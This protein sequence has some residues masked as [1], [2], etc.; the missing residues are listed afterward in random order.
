V[1][2]TKEEKAKRERYSAI[3]QA[4]KEKKERYIGHWDPIYKDC[5]ARKEFALLG[6]Q[7][8]NAERKRYGLRYPLEP[9][10]LLTYVNHEANRT[11]QTDYL[12]KVT[13]NGGGATI[14][15][16]RA[17]QDV[18]RGIQ[19]MGNASS[20]FN[21]ARRDQVASGM[22]YAMAVVDYT[23]K[24]GFG[25]T[26]QYEYMRETFNVFP[27]ISAVE[28]T[29]CDMRDFLIRKKV[30]K[31]Q[32]KKE[33][34]QDPTDWG[35]V[36]EK[37]LWYYW[38]R[39]DLEEQEFLMEDGTT[40]LDSELNKDYSRVKKDESGENLA[41]PYTDIRWRWYKI[42]QDC[43]VIDEE[44]WLGV[45]PPL[46]ACTGRRV[47]DENR[48][49]YQSMTLFAEEP[50]KVYTVLENII[51]LR[52]ARSPYSKWKIPFESID[53][54]QLLE[55]RAAS[56]VGD[57]DILYKSLT[58]D[59]NTIPAPEEIEPHVLDAM[60]VELQREQEKKIQKIFGIFDANLGNKSN[61]QSGVAIEQ[62]RRGGETSNYDFEYNFTE[63]VE[64]ITRVILDLIPRYLSAPQQ[65][66]FVD[67]E[68]NAAIDWINTNGNNTLNPD[69]EYALAIEATPI[70]KTARQEEAEMLMNIAKVSPIVAQNAKVMALVVKAQPGRYSA[71]IADILAG[72][73][74]EIE[75]AKAMITDLQGQLQAAEQKSAQDDMAIA[76]L[77]QTV[78]F[79]KQQQTNLK[80]LA[81]LEGNTEAMRL[82]LEEAALALDAQIREGELQLKAM[83]SESKRMT[84]E[85]SM[86][87][88]VDKASRP[89]PKPKEPGKPA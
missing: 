83:D 44:D 49:H 15:R 18:L 33:T 72:T 32:W 31:N 62:R 20:V 4:F 1:R 55:L 35:S 16:A 80:Q 11:L 54:K 84:A 29:L 76:G 89:D 45:Y 7:L 66:A 22:A 64:Q 6:K 74:P 14:E 56:V 73:N 39:E 34:G 28:N 79:L 59:G 13:P 86:I 5:K 65:V 50:Q 81:S 36:K 63:F 82:K 37:E 9:N 10:L 60:L 12:G 57:Q 48:T 24:R 47:V 23:P 8:D 58:T 41:K 30:Q 42:T 61:E 3:S 40:K 25:K 69:E 43:E 21:Y 52:L 51:A 85:A 67:P 38:V 88:A 26:I 77:K 87:S 71:Q 17:R 53:V 75:Q 46:V 27:D 68:D 70:S 19:R 2:E 78:T